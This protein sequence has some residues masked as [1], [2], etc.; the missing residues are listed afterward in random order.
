MTDSCHGEKLVWDGSDFEA[1]GWHDCRFWSFV[2]IP[3]TFELAI[4]LDYIFKWVR[5]REEG[6]FFSFWVSPAT[7]VFE[8]VH[9]VELEVESSQGTL[10]IAD[11]HREDPRL[12]PNKKFTEHLYRFELQEGE[13]RLRATGFQMYV[14]QEPVLLEQGAFTYAERGGI[15]FERGMAAK[16]NK[17]AD[18]EWVNPVKS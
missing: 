1:M 8:N 13:L 17:D 14:R 18:P 3:E 6:S 15:S 4:D 7:M 12:T 5:P 11:L 10:E 2:A 9:G 16:S